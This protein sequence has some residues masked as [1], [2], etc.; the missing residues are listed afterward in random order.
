MGEDGEGEEAA[1]LPERKTAEAEAMAK[2]G[3]EA[4]RDGYRE[5]EREGGKRGRGSCD[6]DSSMHF[7]ENH[8]YRCGKGGAHS[9]RMCRGS[10][11]ERERETLKKTRRLQTSSPGRMCRLADT[12]SLSSFSFLLGIFT[13]T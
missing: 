11:R 6:C 9:T 13:S 12:V 7:K 3:R 8:Y 10:Q 1:K 5:T 4:S 2:P